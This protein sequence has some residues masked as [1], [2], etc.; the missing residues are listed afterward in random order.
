[1]DSRIYQQISKPRKAHDVKL[2]KQK[3][4]VKASTAVVE[5]LNGLIAI[6]SIEKLLS[7]TIT[8]LKQKAADSLAIL[9]KENIY[10]KEIR[11]D[12]V[13]LQLGKYI[14]HLRFNISKESRKHFGEDASKRITS[15]KKM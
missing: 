6:M 7:Q 15:V 12:D 9:S 4:I 1:M 5:T 10:V 13:L 8:E 3:D 2:Q 14:T 11:K